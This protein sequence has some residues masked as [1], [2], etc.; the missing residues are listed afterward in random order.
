MRH[1]GTAA[2]VAFSVCAGVSGVTAQETLKLAMGQKDNWENQAPA[3][4]QRKGFFS[5]RGL[6][7]EILPTQG[8][9][10]TLQAVISGSV[11]IGIG[12]GTIGAMGAFSKGAPVRVISASVTGAGDVFWYVVANSPVQSIADAKGKT[13]AF[14]TVGAST[15]N[16]VSAFIKQFKLDGARAIPTGGPPSTFTQTMSGQVDIGWSSPPFALDAVEQGRIRIVGRGSD[17]AAT[18][19]QTVRVHIVNANTLRDRREAVVRFMQAYREALDWMYAGDEAPK[20]Y[21]ETLKIPEARAIRVR[22]EFYPKEALSPDRI[23][24]LESQMADG[25]TGKFLQRPL[26]QAEIGEFLHILK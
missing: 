21:A 8:G 12:V 5:A 1:F 20:L 25:V 11:D 13:I 16:M 14:S 18:A 3:L 10:E 4:G 15:Q 6:N 23:S 2:A 17:A 22:Q 7:L 9:G 24:G 26:T 19:D